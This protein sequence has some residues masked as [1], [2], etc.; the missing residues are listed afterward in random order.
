MLH[1]WQPMAANGTLIKSKLRP[2]IIIGPRRPVWRRSFLCARRQGPARSL[3]WGRPSCWLFVGR[4]FALDKGQPQQDAP[5]G[6]LG[7]SIL[8]LASSKGR[9][10]RAL[11]Q[12]A[13]KCQS[14][15]QRARAEPLFG[16]NRKHDQGRPKAPRVS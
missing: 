10:R 4:L 13:C 6:E 5:R 12:L 3:A 15:A 2:F 16:P 8:W 7:H 11:V 9:Q 14:D 1:Q